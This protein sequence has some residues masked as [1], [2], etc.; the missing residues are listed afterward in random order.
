M[1]EKLKQLMH[2]QASTPHFEPVDVAT[3]V[4]RGDRRIRRRRW[5]VVGGSAAAAVAVAALAPA[6]LGAPGSDPVSP[7]AGRDGFPVTTGDLPGDM[8]AQGRVTWAMGSVIHYGD[9]TVDV[10]MPVTAFVRTQIGF[11]FASDG[12]VWQVDG[13]A[14]QLIGHV[15]PKHPRLVSDEETPAAGWVDPT[16]DR[17]AFV[18]YDHGTG[19]TTTFDEETTP[20]MGSL[21][22]EEDPAYFYAVDDGTAY[23]RDQRGAVATDLATGETTVVDAGAR[24]GFDIMDVEDGLIAFNAADDGT[25]L[26]RTR[27]DAVLLPDAYGSMGSFSPDAAFYTADADEP[28]VYATATGEQ[29]QLDLGGYAFAT[30]VGWVDDSTVVV[31][32][33]QTEQSSVELLTCALP[34]GACTAYVDDLG[35]FEEITGSFQLPVGE[36]IED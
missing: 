7:G 29:V 21:A 4:D 33:A 32:A 35:T 6:L 26:G 34:S 18:V 11:V 23:W 27:G 24:N 30:G 28:Q 8:F 16:G 31:L 9:I 2:E 15:H 19:A 36:T 1:T 3:L 10:G 5:A 22:D 20:G 12:E 25:A 13:D 14:Q 17:P